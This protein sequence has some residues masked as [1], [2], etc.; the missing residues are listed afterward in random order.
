MRYVLRNGTVAVAL[1]LA[2]CQTPAG[3]L[4]QEADASPQ[5]P[6]IKIFED[7]CL[8]NYPSNEAGIKA[9]AARYGIT[10][11]ATKHGKGMF[12][13]YQYENGTTAD[14]SLSV[15]YHQGTV[16]CMVKYKNGSGGKDKILPHIQLGRAVQKKFPNVDPTS[17]SMTTIQNGKII[18][19]NYHHSDGYDYFHMG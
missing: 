3:K 15:T 4:Q 13:P 14:Q 5:H 8:N 18:Q 10:N 16:S 9:T 2:G 1:T 19:F 6:A 7:I 12:G 11:F 17:K